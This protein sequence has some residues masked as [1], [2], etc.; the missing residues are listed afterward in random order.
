MD[1]KSK[2]INSSI[3]FFLDLGYE[4]TSL[5][6]IA[7]DIGIKKPS[8][9]YHFKNK[10]ELFTICTFYILESIEEKVLTSIKNSLTAKNIIENICI[11]LIEYNHNLSALINND[12]KHF[13]VEIG[14][15]VYARGEKE[16]GDLWRIGIDTPML[17]SM[18]GQDLQAQAGKQQR[19]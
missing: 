4:N 11:T 2:I 12:Y 17:A 19:E 10:E 7:E 1:T 5:S 9:Y 15:E 13:M 3:K 16:G 8:I 6:M 18:P 14:G